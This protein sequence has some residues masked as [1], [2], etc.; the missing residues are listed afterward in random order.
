MNLYII[1]F[2][3]GHYLRID[4]D[5]RYKT[6]DINKAFIYCPRSEAERILNIMLKQYPIMKGCTVVDRKDELT[7]EGCK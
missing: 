4:N 5:K 6:K 7:N 1:K 2:P 3:D